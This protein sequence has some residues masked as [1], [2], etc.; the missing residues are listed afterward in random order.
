M[1][2]GFGFGAAFLVLSAMPAAGQ[3][4]GGRVDL[5]GHVSVLRLSEIDA[6]DTGIGVDAAWRATPLVALD[7]AFTWFPG[8][9][10]ST[11]GSRIRNQ[12]R[13]LGLIGARSG[14]RR[15]PFEISGRTRAGFLKFAGVEGAVCVAVT[16]FPLPLECQ[17]AAGYTAF[18]MDFGVGIA[19][20]A[21]RRWQ[22]RV[23]VGDLLVRYGQRS[24]RSSGNLTDGFTSHNLQVGSGL[25]WR[26]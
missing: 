13:T 17:L 2:R 6:T 19:V 22:V 11:T 3:I 20:A 15:G 4:S 26:F 10:D 21:G 8:K 16:T 14:I 23:D 1:T 12:Q 5:G 25:T 18:A 7:G 9:D 24:H